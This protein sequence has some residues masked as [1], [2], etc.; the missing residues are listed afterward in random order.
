MKQGGWRRRPRPRRARRA[1]GPGRGPVLVARAGPAGRGVGLG[2]RVGP[3][4]RRGRRRRAGAIRG[5]PD[6]RP[7]PRKSL[8]GPH[9]AQFCSRRGI[10]TRFSPRTG[11]TRLD[12][13]R[14]DPRRPGVQLH[15]RGRRGAGRPRQARSRRGLE[16]RDHGHP[17]GA[18]C[19]LGLPAGAPGIHVAEGLADALALAARLPWPAVCMRGTAGYRNH[20]LA[21][22]LAGNP[23][24]EKGRGPRGCGRAA[25]GDPRRSLGEVRRRSA[26][27]RAA[28]MG[29]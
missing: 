4:A 18:T 13:R 29:G 17:A 22:W 8:Y 27:R 21:A 25:G 24:I 15:P 12:A 19:V 23:S 16:K 2:G 14:A 6:L 11:S 20:A 3:G 26:A 28:W 10:E 7:D 1:F 5:V 9:R